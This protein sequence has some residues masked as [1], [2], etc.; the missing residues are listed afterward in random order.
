[1]KKMI[2][3][4]M[5]KNEADIV[6]TFV[7]YTM[8]Y[9]YKMVI[10]D[11]GCTDGS[12]EI[13]E[14]LI[15]EGFNIEIFTE[16]NVFYEQMFLENKY[17]RKINATEEFD[18]LVP[19]DVDEFLYP[20]NGNWSIFEG[21]PQ[22]QISI[23]EWKT[24]CLDEEKS[25]QNIFEDIDYVRYGVK[26]FT[27][28][29]IPKSLIREGFFVTMGHHDVAGI[30]ENERNICDAIW[31][32]HFPVRSRKQIQFKVYQGILAQLMSSY[33]SVVAFHWK[34]MFIKLKK[35][36]FDVVDYSQKYALKAN[37]I[38]PVY[39]T[40][41]FDISWCQKS[42]EPQY[43]EMINGNMEQLI[44]SLAEAIVLRY[45]TDGENNK[46]QKLL[47]YGTGG[48][49]KNLFSYFRPTD[50]EI[51]AYV[52]SDVAKEYH[53]FNDRIIIGP[54]KIKYLDF[55]HIVIASNY[56]DEIY[57]KL[58]QCNVPKEKIWDKYDLLEKYVN[59]GGEN[60]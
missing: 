20:Q 39:K 36:E 49:A 38:E 10:V 5:I 2:T 16:A 24:Y 18:Y 26:E 40:E 56:R 57:A 47:I 21:L 22:N 29:I 37:D 30:K 9:A 42:V 27:K 31:M 45:I 32:A 14:K 58:S 50:Y 8:N 48:S 51:V 11:N 28:V 19:V 7:R 13:L 44:F 12:R 6:E 46:R 53:K 25:I 23:I 43:N 1:M 3:L 41:K 54:D 34:D 55:D 35:N 52:D 17:I 33:H 60:A 59:M 15:E 4:T